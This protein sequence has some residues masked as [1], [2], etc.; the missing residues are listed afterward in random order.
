MTELSLA[1]PLSPMDHGRRLAA[2][3][4]KMSEL[5]IAQ[6]WVTKPVNVRWLCGFT[7]SNGQILVTAESVTLVTDARYRSQASTELGHAGLGH[8]VD[9]NIQTATPDQALVDLLDPTSTG[10]LNIE[11]DHVTVQRQQQIQDSLQRWTLRDGSAIID[12]LRQIKDVGEL[13]RLERAASIADQALSDVLSELMPGTTERRFAGELEYR[14]KMLG[15]DDVSF[16]TIVASGPNSAMPHHR[17]NDRA[18]CDGDL[19]VVDFGAKVDGYGSDMTR[20]VVVG[21][22]PTKRQT[23]LYDAVASAQAAGVAAVADGVATRDIDEICRA[24]LD[25]S[26]FG[27]AFIHG[28][29]HGLGLEIHEQ[30]MLSSRSVDILRA[31]QAVTVEPGAYLPGFGGVRVE[32]SVVVTLDGC[33]PLTHAPKGLVP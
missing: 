7:G 15:A 4:A 30:P 2:T 8:H 25:A 32:D 21:G 24:A 14:M 22:A 6:F 5:D 12:R 11:N 19:V 16:E 3:R 28:T 20:T 26:G 33:E 27:D 1:T 31:G 17:P 9:I 23:Q 10:Q 18:V 13:A 29:G